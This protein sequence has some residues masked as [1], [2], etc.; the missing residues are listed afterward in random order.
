MLKAQHFTGILGRLQP[1]S[2][3]PFALR[4]LPQSESR[5]NGR[6]N[7]PKSSAKPPERALH[8]LRIIAG[9]WRSRRLMFAPVAGLRPTGD[10]IRETLFNWLLGEIEGARCLDLF[11]GSGALGLEALSRGAASATL[12]ELNPQAAR[13]LATNLALLAADNA[14]LAQADT[15]QWLQQTPPARYDLVFLDPPFDADLWQPV[16]ELLTAKHWL[17]TTALV[18]IEAPHDYTLEVPQN[19]QLHR[20]KRA[21]EV[22]I[23]L[24]RLD[25]G[26]S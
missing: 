7:R 21:G 3:Q 22:C 2:C 4:H 10:R 15:L 20:E 6:K 17:S 16:I 8:Q 23:R 1:L 25:S 24:Y 11:S 13:Q 5:L 26:G 9:K 19:W 14:E 12:L 18:Y